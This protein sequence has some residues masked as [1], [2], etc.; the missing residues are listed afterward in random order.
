[1]I[2]V[3]DQFTRTGSYDERTDA[4]QIVYTVTVTITKCGPKQTWYD[5]V[6]TWADPRDGSLRCLP[7][8]HRMSTS[9]ANA[10]F[11]DGESGNMWGPASDT[12]W[13]QTMVAGVL[14]AV[15]ELPE[16]VEAEEDHEVPAHTGPCTYCGEPAVYVTQEDGEAFCE[17]HW[18]REVRD[19]ETFYRQEAED[20]SRTLIAEE[21]IARMT[22]ADVTD[23]IEWLL[24][25][26]ATDASIRDD[27]PAPAPPLPPY[28]LD[29]VSL[30]TSTW[31]VQEWLV[32][33][34]TD[35]IEVYAAKVRVRSFSDLDIITR[36][37]EMRTPN[38]GGYTLP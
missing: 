22:D 14:V 19:A 38:R 5:R 1:M 23:A 35:P 18:A 33:A 28:E 15:P 26:E 12:P 29:A 2:Q 9:G 7:E 4:L 25:P 37:Q 20:V 8:G 16:A 6:T 27:A 24:S 17:R 31:E 11:V 36:D 3:G 13:T 30:V 32:H 34:L 21:Q 10:E